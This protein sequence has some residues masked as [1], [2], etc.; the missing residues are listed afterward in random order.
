MI[1]YELLHSIRSW[2]VDRMHVKRMGV[3]A[4]VTVDNSYPDVVAFCYPHSWTRNAPI[5]RPRGKVCP[6]SEIGIV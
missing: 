2:P 6:S 5:K 4:C 3:L 1:P